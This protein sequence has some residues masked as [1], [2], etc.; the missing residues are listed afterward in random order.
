MHEFVMA[1][2]ITVCVIGEFFG[3]A[4][5]AFASDASCPVP[6]NVL[7]YPSMH[8][9]STLSKPAIDAQKHTHT[10][11]ATFGLG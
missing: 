5:P 8:T 4:M 9:T 3:V 10:E 11:F 1:L 6:K 7:E 2:F